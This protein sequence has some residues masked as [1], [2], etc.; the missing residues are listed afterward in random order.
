MGGMLSFMTLRSQGKPGALHVQIAKSMATHVQQLSIAAAFNLGWPE[1]VLRM[2]DVFARASSVSDN[3]L[4]PDCLVTQAAVEEDFAG[5]KFFLRATVSLMLPFMLLALEAVFWFCHWACHCRP[6]WLAPNL[7]SIMKCCTLSRS[8]RPSSPRPDQVASAP[9]EHALDNVD[10]P[11]DRLA[12]KH[13]EMEFEV[14][15][16][17]RPGSPEYQMA[18]AHGVARRSWKTS[19]HKDWMLVTIIVT[20]FLLHPT[21]TKICLD[22]LTCQTIPGKEGTF[23]VA[24]LQVQCNTSE[25][26]P[27][28]YGI[29]VSFLLLYAIGIPLAAGFRLYQL[30]DHLHEA[31]VRSRY[32]F[33][34]AGYKRSWYFFEVIIMG[35]KVMLA[36]MGVMLA[37]LGTYT[38]TLLALVTL[39]YAAVIHARAR[40]YARSVMNRLEML[41]LM[42]ALMTLVFGLYLFAEDIASG[43]REFVTALLVIMNG[44]Y[45]VVVLYYLW[46]AVRGKIADEAMAVHQQTMAGKLAASHS[47]M[48]SHLTAEGKRGED[49]ELEVESDEDAGEE[50]ED[51]DY[52]EQE[53][54]AGDREGKPAKAIE[55]I[56][57]R[58]KKME[59]KVAIGA[60][61]A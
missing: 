21:L 27:F 40:P 10:K 24:D 55:S 6:W 61:A 60:A 2:F 30:R 35:R 15:N 47:K 38:Q 52:D 13:S 59:K 20:L 3:V 12:S 56:N 58:G 48:E 34:Y 39:I 1:P 57:A 43:V 9:A 16:P 22:L 29:G 7:G 18:E 37:P 32:G 25:S 36:V 33:L 44:A 26:A 23:L 31:A 46:L 5:S 45:F 50:K 28:M 41:S 4:S 14:G 42:T 53:A 51:E 8:N 49:T 17:M 19:N 54:G 11:G